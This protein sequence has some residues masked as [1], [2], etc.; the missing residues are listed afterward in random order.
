LVKKQITLK[1]EFRKV[2]GIK[3]HWLSLT[4]YDFEGGIFLHRIWLNP[5]DVKKVDKSGFFQP[6][7]LA[8]SIFSKCGLFSL[9]YY[10]KNDNIPTGTE[11]AAFLRKIKFRSE[12]PP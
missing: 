12:L 8:T 10:F 2:L 11:A 1:P 6:T 4:L 9:I 7:E 3:F 5:N